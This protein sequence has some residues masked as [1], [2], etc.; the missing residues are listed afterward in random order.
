[1][2]QTSEEDRQEVSFCGLRRRIGGVNCPTKIDFIMNSVEA[3]K[4]ISC[5]KDNNYLRH[6]AVE[7]VSVIKIRLTCLPVE[8]L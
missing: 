7:L 2:V 4:L 5:I 1:M 8:L 6:R 3:V